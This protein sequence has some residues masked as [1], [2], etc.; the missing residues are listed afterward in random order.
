[1]R[2]VRGALFGFNLV[3]NL[4]QAGF[5]EGR[6]CSAPVTVTPVS[7]PTMSFPFTVKRCCLLLFKGAMEQRNRRGENHLSQ[8]D[9]SFD[10]DGGG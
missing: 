7:A 1:M 10:G 5:Q 8:V 4:L 3:E 6:L 9:S 2:I